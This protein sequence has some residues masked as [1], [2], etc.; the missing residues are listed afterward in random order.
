MLLLCRNME[1]SEIRWITVILVL[2]DG[3]FVLHCAL[4][5]KYKYNTFS[6]AHQALSA[7]NINIPKMLSTLI[8][9]HLISTVTFTLV[10]HYKTFLL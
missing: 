3:C 6:L 4:I 10:I 8:Q 2:S 9:V 5:T 1:N 7:L